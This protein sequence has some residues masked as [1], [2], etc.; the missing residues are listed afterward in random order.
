MHH[1]TT[2]KQV[3]K[4]LNLSLQDTAFILGTDVSN[5]SKYEYGKITPNV[6]VVVGYHLL[7]KIPFDHLIKKYAADIR[8]TLIERITMLLEQKT[9]E[10]SSAK[11]LLQR[12]VLGQ[13]LESLNTNDKYG[14]NE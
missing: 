7:A 10:K 12:E 2:L 1:L 5:L 9:M 14:N 3:R 8:P 4:N 6:R 11:A 13:I